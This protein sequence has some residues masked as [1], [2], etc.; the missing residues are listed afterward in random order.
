MPMDALSPRD[1]GLEE[2]DAR[3]HAAANRTRWRRRILQGVVAKPLLTMRKL[4]EA[5]KPYSQF[6]SIQ[7]IAA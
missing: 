7:S 1:V 4:V 2:A 5:T 6:A 3:I